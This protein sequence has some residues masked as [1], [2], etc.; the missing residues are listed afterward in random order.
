MSSSVS[1]VKSPPGSI[2]AAASTR[3]LARI[4]GPAAP[5]NKLSCRD[6]YEYH[7]RDVRLIFAM[8][9]GT[10]DTDLAMDKLPFTRMKRQMRPTNAIYQLELIRR[11][12]L[13]EV[14]VLP[15]PAQWERPKILGA[16][17]KTYKPALSD[18]DKAFLREERRVLYEIA[19]SAPMEDVQI[20]GKSKTSPTG[21]PDGGVAETPDGAAM[22]ADAPATHHEEAAGEE[23]D[24]A[25]MYNQLRLAHVVLALRDEFLV[26]GRAKVK[27]EGDDENKSVLSVDDENDN[28]GG[29]ENGNENGAAKLAVPPSRSEGFWSEACD[30]FNA[31]G[32]IPKSVAMPELGSTLGTSFS[33]PLSN[34]ISEEALLELFQNIQH[35]LRKATD[36][37][38]ETIQ[39]E[40]IEYESTLTERKLT[41]PNL[42]LPAMYMWELAN[43][44]GFLASLLTV[45]LND[46]VVEDGK[47]PALGSTNDSVDGNNSDEGETEDDN[48]AK[49]PQEQT[50]GEEDGKASGT[51]IV[52]ADGDKQAAEASRAHQLVVAEAE[53]MFLRSQRL[54]LEQMQMCNTL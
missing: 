27:R 15:R 37:D 46:S 32:W 23:E 36:I 41:N 50:E 33:V 30:K 6:F 8:T 16:L 7:Q 3:R 28:D 21:G 51:A 43:L 5:A 54:Y 12:R 14:A 53:S 18:D 38:P 25:M 9:V 35:A 19:R 4:S 24:P 29:D 48:Q 26:R 1:V 42:S 44:N 31:G 34:R 40:S 45:A 2:V 52:V 13:A 49:K 10:E 17:K 47:E 22:V 39:D 11:A 20:N